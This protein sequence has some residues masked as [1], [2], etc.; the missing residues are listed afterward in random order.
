MRVPINI[1]ITEKAVKI[2]NRDQSIKA[3]LYKSPLKP[4]R[5]L[6]AIINKDVPTG[7]E[8]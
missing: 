5:D 2:N 7:G 1:P 3:E 4:I 6:I 8:G